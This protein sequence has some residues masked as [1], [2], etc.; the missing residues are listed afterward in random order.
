[1]KK[2][3][4]SVSFAAL[5]AVSGSAFAGTHVLTLGGT[6]YCSTSLNSDAPSLGG[7]LDG[8]SH[9]VTT[10]IQTGIGSAACNVEADVTVTS[11]NGGL[12]QGGSPTATCDTNATFADCIHYIADVSWNNA[13]WNSTIT[14][15]G[16]GTNGEPQITTSGTAGET[17]TGVTAQANSGNLVLTLT[18][19]PDTRTVEYG[20]Y[21][22]TVTVGVTAHP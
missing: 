18:P 1:M 21:G 9:I 19:L 15:G 17:N 6:S 11:A 2:L 14:P 13:V 8:E 7:V 22:D 4:A 16:A 3:L 10:P 5:I 20:A 12:K